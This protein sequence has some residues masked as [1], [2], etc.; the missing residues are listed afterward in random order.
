MRNIL[1]RVVIEPAINMNQANLRLVT[2]A[3]LSSSAIISEKVIIKIGRIK[4]LMR[5]KYG[6]IAP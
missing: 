4:R 2:V 1:K 3:F 6:T 5:Y